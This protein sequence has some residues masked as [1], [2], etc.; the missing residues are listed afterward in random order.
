VITNIKK[1]ERGAY[2]WHQGQVRKYTGEAY[3]LHP[4]AVAAIVAALSD[5]TEA[6]IC[7]AWLHDTVE[8][9]DC[10]LDDVRAMCGDEVAVLVEMLT[11]PSKPEDGNRSARKA[12]DLLH[13]AMASPA[14]KTIKLADLIDNTKSIVAHDPEFAK[15]YLEEKRK[16]LEVLK[17][18]DTGLWKI[19]NEQCQV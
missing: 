19:A 12:I 6:M 11:D 16:L 4:R 5:A 15:V 8:D 14:A 18:G 13:T 3:F 2:A 10:T 9:T 17:D 1:A 7:A